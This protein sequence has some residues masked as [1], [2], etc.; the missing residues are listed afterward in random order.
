MA[1]PLALAASLF[2]A[3]APPA[4]APL[5]APLSGAPSA[6]APVG[7]PAPPERL[8]TPAANPAAYAQ[9]RDLAARGE[10]V[11][12][13][14]VL[15]MARTPQAE[16]LTG[17]SPAR[18]ERDARRV[19]L[20]AARRR[21]VP[22]LVLY[23]V[24]G[25]DCASYSG[26]GAATSAQYRDWIDAV[27]RGIGRERALVVLEP[28]G[29]ALLPDECGV[30]DPGGA[31]TA[32]R[33]AELNHAVDRLEPLPGTRVYL[34]AGHAAWHEVRNIA[35]RLRKAGIARARGFALNVSNYQT[36]AANS[37]YGELI[38]SCLAHIGRGGTPGT[39]P[40]DKA[41]RGTVP[42]VTDSSRNGRGPWAPPAGRYKDPQDWC[43]PPGRGLGARPTLGTGEPL[44]DARLWIKTPGESD[45]PCLRGAPGPGDPARG[46]VDPPAGT[47]F[48]QQALELVRRARPAIA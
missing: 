18:A 23:N 5:G 10:V 27:A 31:R 41:P 43:N 48:P 8:H 21:A 3:L 9:A 34:D 29:L 20:D 22:V 6:P 42:F 28:D 32:A 35:P 11:L 16:W 24:P 33:Y 44:H 38:S 14:G 37:R 17:Q 15:S 19:V 2:L 46:T 12:A 25:R 36:D 39:C 47:W 13:Q 45:G 30:P 4:P 7:A 1:L 40:L 26:G